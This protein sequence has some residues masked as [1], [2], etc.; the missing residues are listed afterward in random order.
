MLK[1]RLISGLTMGAT[2]LA[3]LF[4][5]PAEGALFVLLFIN[6]L[7]LREFYQLLDAARIP[8]FNRFGVWGGSI[9]LA[10][11][12]YEYRHGIEG[13]SHDPELLTLFLMSASIFMRQFGPTR[14]ERPLET[15]A[16]TLMGLI[17]IA[18]MLNF[19]VRLL[20]A[21]GPMGSR[22]LVFYTILVVKCTD[23]GA[24]FT[25]RAF[26]RRRIFPT[27]SPNKT[28]E[29]FV[30]GIAFA[31][32]ASFAVWFLA[33]GCLGPLCFTALD[34]LLLGLLLALTGVVGDLFESLLKRAAGV[35]DS[36]GMIR[37]MGGVLD[38]ID[39]LLPAAPVVYFY[40][41]FFL[42]PLP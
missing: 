22:I 3:A 2:L 16:G 12:W 39:S 37:G 25:G 9:L 40:A 6:A 11:T 18:F 34:A 33:E 7:A 15:M 29:G 28:W 42:Q 19:F 30:G 24:Y 1:F 14:S 35:K 41:R 17:Y 38:V 4:F 32:A 36:G 26:G 10:V 5:L 23:I 13:A 21:W 31:L 8:N 27:L 20:M